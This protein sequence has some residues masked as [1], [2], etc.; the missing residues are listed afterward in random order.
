MSQVQIESIKNN[1]KSLSPEDKLK[2]LINYIEN[3]SF[4]VTIT[5]RVI[6][7]VLAS[8]FHTVSKLSNTIRH[9]ALSYSVKLILVN[10]FI[11]I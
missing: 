10:H 11:K 9:S 3:G 1:I 6:D 5:K 7:R 4:D 2:K 8:D